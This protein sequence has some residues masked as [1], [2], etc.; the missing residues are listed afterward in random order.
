MHF[1]PIQSLLN[2]ILHNM[3]SKFIPRPAQEKILTYRNGT[4]GVSA[5]PG[6]GKTWTLSFL[7]AKLINEGLVDSSQEILVVTLVNSAVSNFSSRIGAFLEKFGSIPSLGYRIRTLHGLAHDIV[8]ERPDLVGLDA[9]FQIID[10]AESQRIRTEAINIWLKD[11]N[12]VIDNLLIADIKPEKYSSLFQK[13]IP[14]LLDQVAL[15]F[16]RTAKNLL[17]TPT[18]ISNFLESSKV[19]Y[20]LAI[21]G[22]EVYRIYQ[23]NLEY[24]GAIDFD[25]LIGHAYTILNL[26]ES[27]L[28]RLK[29]KWPY[30]LEDEAQ[31]SSLIQQKILSLLSGNSKGKNWVR[32]GDP[33]QG[34]Y[35]SF[36]TAD[37][38]LLVSFIKNAD[39]KYLLPNSGRST[40]TI[41]DLANQLVRWTVSEHPQKQVRTALI[42][43][44]IE[45]APSGDVQPNPQAQPGQVHL[46]DKPLSPEDEIST[47]AASA[48]KWIKSHPDETVVIL[49]P[50]NERGKKISNR[51]R[52]EHNT[53]PVELL[54]TTIATR[55]ATGALVRILSF[56][57]EPAS[58]KK[59]SM[60]Y[61]VWKRDLQDEPN[62]WKQVEIEANLIAEIKK[63]ESFISPGPAPDWLSTL[64]DQDNEVISRFVE[65]SHIIDRWQQAFLLPIDQ[66][67]LTLANDIF[68]TPEEL[69]L[70][71][72][73]S[74]FIKSLSSMH[75]DWDMH[76]L[77]DELRSLARNERRFFIGGED[78]QF[79]PDDYK[80]KIVVT[81]AHKSKGLEWDRVY[82]MSV[83]NYNFPSGSEFDTYIP[84]KW[85]VRD[86]LNLPAESLAQLTALNSGSDQ[87]YLEGDASHDARYEYIRERLRLLYVAVT[88]AKKELIITWNT[89]NNNKLKPAIAL[90]HLIDYLSPSRE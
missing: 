24:K 9:S 82:L 49:A 88:R 27:L 79:N 6:S 65:F 58:A 73:L 40:Q 48:V 32:V 29:A 14:G 83:N 7:A 4:M 87:I 70:S 38:E 35:E 13:Q 72:K 45:P 53:E 63:T 34:I 68:D 47:V 74:V 3:D 62:N 1:V 11:N 57:L 33:N 81:T 16:I 66:L 18:A 31:D 41:I 90:D 23:R 37:P 76:S 55:K 89:G 61:K 26:D 80:G 44:F 10:D 60:V 8:K 59:L 86:N 75:P 78:I 43:N 2:Q 36:T 56:L 5:V 52:A 25:D 54:N 17:L 12:K 46:H 39:Y 50:R 71:Q 42:Q 64:I 21:F 67:I 30:I 19:D 69:S 22:A 20:S 77:V 84:E 51:L 28:D 85:F 15:Q